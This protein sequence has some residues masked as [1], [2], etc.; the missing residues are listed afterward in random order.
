MEVLDADKY[1]NQVDS[2][3]RPVLFPSVTVDAIVVRPKQEDSN[4]HEI[5]MITRGFEPFKGCLAFPGGFVD[6][7]EDPINACLRELHEECRIHSSAHSQ[8]VLVTVAGKPGRD[9]RKHVISIFYKIEVDPTA[10]P[11]AGDDAAAA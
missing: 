8:P 11:E 5:L 3:G 1:K 10:Q 2:H 7:N 9:P 4:A 6:Y